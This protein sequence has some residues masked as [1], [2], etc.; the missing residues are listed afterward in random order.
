[1]NTTNNKRG[2]IAEKAMKESL[3]TQAIQINSGH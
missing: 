3:S 1:V 2:N